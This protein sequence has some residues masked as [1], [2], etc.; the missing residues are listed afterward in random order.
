MTGD[1]SL[2][3]DKLLEIFREER[4]EFRNIIMEL[5]T[6]QF[7]IIEKSIETRLSQIVSSQNVQAPSLNTQWP[8]LSPSAISSLMC[9]VVQQTDT[10]LE[11]STRAVLVGYEEDQDEAV[12]HERDKV[13]IQ[14]VLEKIGDPHLTPLTVSFHRHPKERKSSSSHRIIKIQFPDKLARDR[15]LSQAH[16]IRA[17][18][19]TGN[20]HA[21][22]RRDFTS[23]E[24]TRDRDLRR[25]AGRRNSEQ[26][27]LAYVVRDL[28]IVTLTNP[29]PLPKRSADNRLKYLSQNQYQINPSNAPLAPSTAQVIRGRSSNRVSRGR[30]HSVASTR[31]LRS[32]HSNTRGQSTKRGAAF[33]DV[34]MRFDSSTVKMVKV[35]AAP[36]PSG[37]SPVPSPIPC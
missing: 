35:T 20:P 22:L 13:L 33:G 18:S 3:V 9:R 1:N 2:S 31:N 10:I 24:L 37:L 15:F 27:Q 26:N 6:K 8:D 25:E 11:K 17:A 34:D 14:K 36:A 12:T 30:H 32:S 19:L 28:R 21:F 23:E 29:R 16:K 5:I 7:E 4:N